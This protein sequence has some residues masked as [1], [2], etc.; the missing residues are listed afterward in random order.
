[1]KEGEAEFLR[2]ATLVKRYGA[3]AIVMAFDEKGQADTFERKVQI[4]QRAYELLTRKVGFPPEDIIFDPN[5]FAIATGIEEHDN[6][7]VDFIEATRAIKQLLPHARISGGVSNISFSFRGNEPVR[8]A[9]HSVFLYHAIAAGMDMGI[10]NAGQLAIYEQIQ[11]QLREACED[12]VL[13]R[14]ADATERLLEIA[15]RFKGDGGVR[16][17]EDLEWRSLPV[18]KRIEHALIKGI[19][20][21]IIEDTEAARLLFAR[22]LEV[23]EGP[24]MD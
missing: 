18:P 14:R 4:C 15:S 17:I 7:A 16:R 9:M 20:D 21:F 11:P 5:I 10:V 6:Y 2:Q 8:R 24:L 19:D 22:P 23:I 13:N 12:V 1:M 3:A